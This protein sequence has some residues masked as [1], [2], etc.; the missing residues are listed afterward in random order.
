[1]AVMVSTRKEASTE[2]KT[3]GADQQLQ[4]DDCSEEETRDAAGSQSYRNLQASV[5]DATQ[6]QESITEDI[7]EYGT[8]TPKI[9]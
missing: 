6:S 4:S 3:V 2:A 8:G 1:M 5:S 7:M 9:D